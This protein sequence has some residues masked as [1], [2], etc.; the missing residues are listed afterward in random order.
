MAALPLLALCMAACGGKPDNT[1][2]IEFESFS[3]DRLGRVTDSVPSGLSQADSL[4]RF[5]GR[6]V[7]PTMIGNYDVTQLRDS[8][9]S[10]AKVEFTERGECRPVI[11]KGFALT[12]FR[13]DSVEA[14]GCCID[15][16]TVTLVSPYLIVWE[17][18]VY[19]YQYGAA[20]G[21][22]QWT[23]V[24]F[25][26][27]CGRILS[28]ADIMKK[29]YGPRLE[30]M[31]RERLAMRDDLFDDAAATASVPSVFRIVPDG[32]EFVWQQYEIAPYST[33]VVRVQLNFWELE[34]L[35]NSHAGHIFGLGE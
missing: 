10:L 17:D 27:T 8:L 16:L 25:D 13:P 6:G 35:L 1:R 15:N 23:Y 20:H 34:G 5:S 11:P 30:R 19:T 24:N 32:L 26:V 22:Q 14:S 9:R 7:L 3:Y 29:G 28:V 33:G 2:K 12:E 18:Y 31:L 4:C 21:L